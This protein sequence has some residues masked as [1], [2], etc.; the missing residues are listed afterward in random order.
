MEQELKS[1][2]DY[3][4]KIQRDDRSK[5]AKQVSDYITEV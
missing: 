5:T 3:E 4:L 2:I 1:L